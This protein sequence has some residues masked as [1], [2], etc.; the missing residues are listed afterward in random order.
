MAPQDNLYDATLYIMATSKNVIPA[1]AGI[2]KRL[3]L[4]DSHLSGSNRLRIIRGSLM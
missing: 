3:K 1:K 2:H 4:L